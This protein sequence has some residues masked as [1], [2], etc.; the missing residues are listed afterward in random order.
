MY[1]LCKMTYMNPCRFPRPPSSHGASLQDA[2][3]HRVHDLVPAK[4]GI[5]QDDTLIEDT[6]ESDA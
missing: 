1:I 5:C 4:I 2:L 6:C 3:A